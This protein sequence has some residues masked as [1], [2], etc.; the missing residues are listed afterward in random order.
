M[1]Q[2][3]F[4]FNVHRSVHRKNILIYFQ[5]DATLKSLFYLVT[6]VYMFRVVPPP[7]IRKACNCIYSIWYLSHHY[8]TCRCV[9]NTKYCRYSCMCSWCW[10]EVPP[11]ICRAV[12]R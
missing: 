4:A 11:K 6:A 8:A 3:M 10:V 9:T 7:I 2:E 1:M 12:S 5:Q